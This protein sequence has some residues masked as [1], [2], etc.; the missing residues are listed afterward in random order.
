[1]TKKKFAIVTNIEQSE[2][3]KGSLY[4]TTVDEVL[5]ELIKKTRLLKYDF[6]KDLG[7][8]SFNETVFKDILGISVITTDFRRMG[9]AAAEMILGHTHTLEYN[10]FQMIKRSS[11]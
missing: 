10:P 3:E 7:V 6:G 2:I 11:F 9:I 5:A 4:V 8:I 1:L